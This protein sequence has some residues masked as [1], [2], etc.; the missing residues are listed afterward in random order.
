MRELFLRACVKV[1]FPAL[2]LALDEEVAARCCCE[3]VE[4][5]ATVPAELE[6]EAASEILIGD[7][8]DE[9]E[10]DDVSKGEA[11]AAWED[12]ERERV[13]RGLDL[14]LVKESPLQFCNVRMLLH[15]QSSRVEL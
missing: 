10:D 15:W 11:L 3:V 8:G 5:T 14:K 6:A 1:P 4:T 12:G 7:D 13:R 2:A 9:E